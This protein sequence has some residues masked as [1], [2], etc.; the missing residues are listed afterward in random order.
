MICRSSYHQAFAD[1]RENPARKSQPTDGRMIET[2]CKHRML[3]FCSANRRSD[4]TA[5]YS[6]IKVRT[7]IRSSSSEKSSMFSG[8]SKLIVN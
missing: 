6:C 7:A 8:G 1:S 5:C 4:T 2:S 3:P